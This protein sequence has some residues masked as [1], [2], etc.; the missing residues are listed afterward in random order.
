[1][2]DYSTQIVVLKKTK[3]GETDLIITGFS[4]EGQQVRT[5]AKGARK[6]GSKLGVHLELYAVASVLLHTGRSLD[7]V[8]EA[9]CLTSNEACRRDVLHSAGAAVAVEMLDKVSAQGD[10]EARLFP[11][12]CEGLR[13][14]GEVGDE[15][16]ALI[17]AAIM[18]KISSQLGF[19]PSLK[20]CVCC[21]G[22]AHSGDARG[23]E[24]GGQ[25]PKQRDTVP[26]SFAQ[27]GIIC[28]DCLGQMTEASARRIDAQ[29]IDWAD[30]LITGRFKD[31]EGYGDAQHEALGRALLM[32]AREWLRAHLV[33]RLKSLDFLLS[34]G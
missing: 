18:L 12:V 34:F 17:T 1:M 8:T 15:G 22:D 9:H 16:V 21:G 6:P 5:V 2:P 25:T 14:I 32:F 4:S 23:T 30:V 11:L 24:A 26:F 20:H 27:G 3:L 10:T 31:L 13:C 19:R 28:E 29:L 7:I 33:P